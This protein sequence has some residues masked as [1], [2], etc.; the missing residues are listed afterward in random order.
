MS[1]RCL[2]ACRFLRYWAL[3][4]AL[5]L[6]RVPLGCRRIDPHEG[7]PI[8]ERGSLKV[9]KGSWRVAAVSVR[10]MSVFKVLGLAFGFFPGARAVGLPP[11][12]PP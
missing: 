1:L 6:G 11:D 12:R 2:C 9:P 8:G 7:Q 4:L 5:S 10:S 3:R